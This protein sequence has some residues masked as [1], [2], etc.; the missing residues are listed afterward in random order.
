MNNDID[1]VI[2]WVDG[3]DPK[4]LSKKQAALGIDTQNQTATDSSQ[5]RYRDWDNLKYIFRGIECF[6]PWVRKVFFVTDE[7]IPS[8][9]NLEND[10]LVVVN[11]KDYMP[12]EYL[13]CFSANPIELNFH[14]LP[15]ISERFIVFNDDF[16]ITDFVGA[17]N[18]FKN[19]KPVDI[20]MEYPVMCG[21]NNP[22]FSSMLT[23]GFNL[24]GK[25]FD[26]KQYKKE[27]R[28]KIL[29]LSYGAYFFY[30]L[31]IY[32]L[33]FPRFF[34]LLTPHFARPYLKSSYEELWKLEHEKLDSTCRNHFRDRDD[35]N[36]YIFRN[37]N[38][39][40][41][42]FIP[43]NIHKIGRAFFIKNADDAKNTADKI[44]NRKY[45]LVC[46]NDECDSEGFEEC[47]NIINS[48]LDKILPSK[49]KFEI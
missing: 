14:R 18:F 2:Y 7:Q 15:G 20:L 19:G 35:V 40:K 38:L 6:A 39:L 49:C 44:Q 16:F 8:W 42:N 32:M 26:R 27:L 11:H 28:G 31:L 47:R 46:I 41:G 37:Y 4:W 10:Q 29:S 43:A 5:N 34:G 22:I 48:S 21:G 13:P 9:M 24:I 25:Y 12:A 1:V 23:N 33:P 30:N 17:E 45:K 3:N 36:I